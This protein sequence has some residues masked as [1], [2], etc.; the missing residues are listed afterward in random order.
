LTR[1]PKIKLLV[2]R[3]KKRQLGE[4]ASSPL[5]ANPNPNCPQ[6]QNEEKA[7]RRTEPLRRRSE[8][9]PFFLATRGRACSPRRRPAASQGGCPLELTFI[10]ERTSSP[11]THQPKIKLPARAE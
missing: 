6:G 3:M 7:A 5:H 9:S 1:Q 8:P 11:L 2:R 4:R 10:G